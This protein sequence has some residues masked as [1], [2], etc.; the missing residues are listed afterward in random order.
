MAGVGSAGVLG[1]ASGSKAGAG[2]RKS[3][4]DEFVRA[5]RL[6]NNP[7]LSGDLG[8]GRFAGG[9]SGNRGIGF[10]ETPRPAVRQR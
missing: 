8:H 7:A 4:P 5:A 2:P 9:A 1:L 3:V 6:R 10:T